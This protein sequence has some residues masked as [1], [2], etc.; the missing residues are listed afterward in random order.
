VQLLIHNTLGAA[1]FAHPLSAGWLESPVP[2]ETRDHLTADDVGRAATAL[3]PAPEIAALMETHQIVPQI[4][5]IAE[6]FGLIAMRVPRRPDQIEATPVRLWHASST[7][8]ILARAVL[9][10]FY[11]I[12]PTEWTTG[13]A[14]D[15]QVVIVEGATA[16][17]PPE[18]GYAE[19]MVRAWFI[20]TGQPVVT[21]LLAVPKDADPSDVDSIVST[22][23]QA[24]ALSESRRR[25]FRRE[26][27]AK[28]DL[29]DVR[30]RL[31][32][33]LKGQRYRL[34]EPDRRALL[35]LLQHGNKGSRFPYPW[36][37]PYLELPA[38]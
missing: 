13:D 29:A 12:R 37:L 20:L 11:G 6:G 16:L 8:E 33:T 31:A 23:E 4:A 21:H 24:H 35:M 3:I 34:D 36:E 15:A 10:P 9:E 25:D 17:Q 30:D 2:F 26:I 27:A 1:P 38:E 32:D 5:V 14:P 18:T 22:L 7:G 28:Y 19:D